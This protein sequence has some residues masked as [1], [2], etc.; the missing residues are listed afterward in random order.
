LISFCASD[1]ILGF[2]GFFPHIK[3][4]P[5]DL[6]GQAISH[7]RVLEK[8]GGG[9]MGVVY[10]AEDNR[11]GRQVALKFLPEDASE[12]HSTLERFL[13]EARTASSLNHPNICTIHDIG[14]HEGRPF[15]AMELLEGRTLKHALQ[16]RTLAIDELLDLAIQVADGLDAAHRRG[17]VH[18]DIKP[19]NIFLTERGQA[20]ILDFGLAKLAPKRERMAEAAAAA[21][22]QTMEENLTSPGA[23]VGTVAYMS[24]E[25]ALGKEVDSRTDLFS[26]GVV[27]YEMATRK[28]AFSGSTSAAI[29]DAIL[30]RAP[31]APVQ[32][33][34]RLPAELQRIINKALEKDREMR[35]Q[36]ASELLADLKRLKRDTDSGRQAA[37]RADSGAAP[38]ADSQAEKSMAVLY[39][40]NLSRSGEDEYFRDGITEDVITE[41]SNIEG[42]R[43]FPRSAVFTFRDKPANEPQV[44]QQLGAAYVLSGSLRRAGN[45]LR[46]T[47]QLVETRSGHSVWAKRYDRQ[48]EDVFAIQDEIAHSIAA[49]L[50]LALSDKEKRAIGKAP[51]I[52]VKAYDYYLRGRQFFHQFRRKGFEFAQQMFERAIEIDPHYARAYAGIADCC[53]FLYTYWHASSNTLEQADAA[54]RKALELDPDLAD[55]HASRGLAVSLR[56]DYDEASKEFEAAIRLDPKLFEGYYFYARAMF[57]QGKMAEA[58]D[59]FEKA[60]QVNPDDYQSPALLA[61]AYAG[62]GR[63][64]ESETAR[65]R[66]LKIIEK[67]LEL[68]PDDARALYM[69]AGGL[70]AMGER[71][72]ALEW[73]R[74]ALAIE[75]DDPGVL[76]NVACNYSLLGR[77]EEAIDCLEKAINNGFGFKQW[78]EHDSDLDSLRDIPRFQALVKRL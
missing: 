30:N 36:V 50:K 32:L 34:P 73:A 4:G 27:L 28:Q 29:F 77:P 22:T 13:R 31:S 33:N 18:R 8:L 74:R 61:T 14:E 56:K 44:G 23:A 67:H 9:G 20:K 75:P 55:A 51:T 37:A 43:V 26:F 47:A 1:I 66:A 52:N 35:Y 42:L 57:A 46:I 12:D 69:G 76:Y 40:E 10:K 64:E 54:S 45:R 70:C 5:W 7:Y 6:I 78:I 60:A 53:S 65:R 41:L 17:I 25:Q 49:A 48:M 59:L 71:Q 21:A 68:H 62:L 11:L 19:A 15:I 3:P 72:R 38:A 63:K 16:D 2:G 39:F 58:V 24:P